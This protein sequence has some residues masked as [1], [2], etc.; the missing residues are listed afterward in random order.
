MTKNIN[1]REEVRSSGPGGEAQLEFR[2]T[3]EGPINAY[4][5]DR[6]LI[7]A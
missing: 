7:P 2:P 5:D 6:L 4:K 1:H 3:L